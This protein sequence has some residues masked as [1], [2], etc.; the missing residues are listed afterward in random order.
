MLKTIL[1]GI[2][3]VLTAFW[4]ILLIIKFGWF[5]GI[6][7]QDGE[8]GFPIWSMLIFLFHLIVFCYML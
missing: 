4:F 1:F 6:L 8:S 5:F 3:V 7:E 2:M